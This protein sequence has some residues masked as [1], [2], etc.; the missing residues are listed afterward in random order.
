MRGRSAALLC[1]ALA[2]LL[3]LF[4][5]ASARGLAAAPWS[6][7]RAAPDGCRA[8]FLLLEELGWR[9]ERRHR[10]LALIEDAPALVISIA[11]ESLDEEEV[12]GLAAWIEQGGAWLLVGGDGLPDVPG[13][14][15]LP[16]S[17]AA[18]TNQNLRRG[19]AAHELVRLVRGQVPPGGRIAFDEHHHGLT[20]ERGIAA[21]IADRGLTLAAV[22]LALVA[23][24]GLWAGRR[25]AAPAPAAAAA[26]GATPG[27]PPEDELVLALADVYRR[28]RAFRHAADVLGR[29]AAPAV[30]ALPAAARAEIEVRRRA[31]SQRRGREGALVAYARALHG[32]QTQMQRERRGG[33]GRG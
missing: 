22:Q 11:P 25:A 12:E 14:L 7:Y 18:L 15:S 21:Y 27:A 20:A 24:F 8:L 17:P 26:D 33:H 3:W 28:G 4:E 9:P 19:T 6:S 23:W 30:E 2:G 5:G 10:D 31:M 16:L 32:A 29:A 13:R 1:L